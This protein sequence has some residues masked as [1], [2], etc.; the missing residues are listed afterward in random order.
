MSKQPDEPLSV[1]DAAEIIGV[2]ERR[3]RQFCAAG[4]L[5]KRVGPRMF[6]ITRRE[7]EAFAKIERPPGNPG[8]RS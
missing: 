8:F 5:G 6:V 7:A 2:S 1:K 4:K 3:V